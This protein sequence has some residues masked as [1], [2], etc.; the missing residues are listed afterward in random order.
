MLRARLALR[1]GRVTRVPS[2]TLVKSAAVVEMMHAATLLHDDV[3]DRADVRRNLPAYWVKQG[4]SAAILAG[5]FLVCEAF[6][7]IRST[8]SA[9]LIDEFVSRACDTCEAEIEQELVFRNTKPQ[10]K[11]CID[12]ARRKTGALFALAAVAAA[13]DDR[14]MAAALRKAGFAVGTAYQLADDLLDEFGDAKVAGKTLGRDAQ[15]GKLTAAAV[16][17]AG[18]IGD[19]ADTVEEMIAR[20]GS[21]LK[22]WPALAA[23]WQEYLQSDLRPSL[24]ICMDRRSAL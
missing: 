7:L 9:L 16:W 14:Q 24:S 3:I 6:R 4:V 11:Q 17:K 15:D 21:G 10:W 18:G 5:D 22:K 13:G 8:G 20:S 1:T 23:A 19:P 2:S 12:I